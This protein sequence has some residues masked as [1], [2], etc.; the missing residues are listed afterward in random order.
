MTRKKLSL[1]ADRRN[2]YE[3]SVYMQ[4]VQARV[5]AGQVVCFDE[6][7]RVNGMRGMVRGARGHSVLAVLSLRGMLDVVI[8]SARGITGP[9]FMEDFEAISC[10]ASAVVL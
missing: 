3:R 8:S 4:M 1:I 2:E 10:P 9:A 6:E 7:R 5:Q